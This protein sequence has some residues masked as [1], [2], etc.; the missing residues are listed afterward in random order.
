MILVT[1]S[2]GFVGK[3]LM[4]QLTDAREYNRNDV[5]DLSGI[6]V[7]IHLACDADSRNS[8][9][10]IFSS[11]NDNTGVFSRVL[12]EAV[13]QKVRRFIYVSSVEA[14]TEH[15]IYATC[16]SMNEKILKLAS[17]E[18]GFEYVIIRPSNLYGPYMDLK[19]T[20]RNVIGNFMRSLKEKKQMDIYNG[21]EDKEYKFTYIKTLVDYVI[22][23]LEYY[24]NET[25]IVQPKSSITINDLSTFLEGITTTWDWVKEQE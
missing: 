19:N 6:D 15:N 3:N 5:L 2:H 9:K 20:N 8:N 23:S 24:T 21:S 22:L 17:K 4:E 16:K 13:K 10:H 7:V 1:G 12:D 14:E 25:C 18:Y 11:I